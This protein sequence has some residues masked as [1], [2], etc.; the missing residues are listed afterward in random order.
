M[1]DAGASGSTDARRTDA[2]LTMLPCR[3]Q[4]SIV[5]LATAVRVADGNT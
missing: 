3:H 5:A 2:I 4:N 1:F